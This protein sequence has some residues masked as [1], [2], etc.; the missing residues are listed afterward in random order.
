MR[1]REGENKEKRRTRRGERGKRGK[2]GGEQ[3]KEENKENKKRGEGLVRWKKG[4]VRMHSLFCDTGKGGVEGE[5]S[6][7]C[8]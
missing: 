2:R 7:L 4:N 6:F 5:I 8:H 3:R 1:R